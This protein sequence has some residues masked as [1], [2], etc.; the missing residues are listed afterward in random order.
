MKRGRFITW[1]QLRVG[2]VVLVAAAMLVFGVYK[3][4][5]AANLLGRRYKLVAFVPN[6]NGLRVG[7]AVTVAGQLVGSVESI[8][9]LPADN[10][11][12]RNLRIVVQLDQRIEQQVRADSRARLR[13][14]GLLGD[15][16]FDI[17]PGTT[18]TNVLRPGDTITVVPTVEYEQVIQ[19]AS[20]AVGDV[21]ELTHD[22]HGITAGIVRGDGTIGQL[23]TSRGLYDQLNATLTRTNALLT[24]MQNPHGTIGRLMTD[25]ALYENLTRTSA[26]L[27]TLVGQVSRSEGTLGK[28]LRDDTLY[29]RL[30]NV[31]AGADSLVKLMTRGNG[32]VPRLLTDQASYDNLNKALTELNAIL[33]DV[34]KNP[35]K[36]TRG[37][38]KVF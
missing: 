10:D 11:T 3:L 33:E 13:T 7:G 30:V 17:S 34:R 28:L 32:V 9:F 23:V 24:N 6:A 35:Q 25:P 14:Q 18:H 1:E 26:A 36:Y 21:V 29:V 2:I 22:L 31:A 37:L 16:V 15:R 12:T 4:A 27:D 8:D 38:I 19:Q 20:G 5:K